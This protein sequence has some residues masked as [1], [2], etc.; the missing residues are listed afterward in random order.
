MGN[1]KEAKVDFDLST[2]SLD[3]LIE[4]YNKIDDFLEFCKVSKLV[5]EEEENE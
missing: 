2:L 1:K 4:V 3:E 5:E